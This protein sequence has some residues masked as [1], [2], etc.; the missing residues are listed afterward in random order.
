MDFD[1]IIIGA[2]PAG[3][4]AAAGLAAGGHAVGVLEKLPLATLAEPPFDGREIALTHRSARILAD[5]GI[6][7][8]IDAQEISPLRTAA[9]MNGVSP[10]QLRFAPA[11][12]DD[13]VLGHLV[14]NHLIRRAAFN[15]A[16]EAPR[17]TLLTER[18]VGAVDADE[19]AAVVRATS[20]ES[21]RCRLVIAADS[22]FSTTRRAAGIAA[23]MLDFGKTMLVCRMRHARTR[24]RTAVEWFHEDFTL[25][26]LPLRED[27]SSVVLTDTAAQVEGLLRMDPGAFG[28]ELTWRF[29][30]RCGR[31]E[32]TSTRHAYPLVA[33]F[34]RRVRGARPALSGGGAGGGAPGTA[35]GVKKRAG[36]Y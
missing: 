3:L 9:V 32:L 24:E 23:D 5:C 20:G 4:C 13:E 19:R 12:G 22:R 1:I 14:P 18:V 29:A 17:V 27:E 15:A 31:L 34:A 33:S 6:W 2:G 8:R 25:A 30:Q 26:L 35:P 10:Y 7:S 11:V 21:W 16:G 36:G 28:R